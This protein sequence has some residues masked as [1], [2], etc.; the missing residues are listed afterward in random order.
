MSYQI[1]QKL[2][3][4]V[5]RLRETETTPPLRFKDG[6]L[7]SAMT[8][9]DRFVPKDNEAD[10]KV[11]RD[12]KGIGTERTRDSIIETLKQRKYIVLG[13]GGYLKPTDLGIELIMR[14]PRELSDPVTT[15]KWEMALGLIEQGK[16]TRQQFDVMIRSNATKLVD[17]LKGVK[18][19][20]DRM[21]LK[22]VDDKPREEKPRPE[23]DPSLPGHGETCGKCR[24]GVME[25]K[26]F[27][28]GKKAI[29]CSNF[30]SCKNTKWID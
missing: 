6:T 27:S 5:V 13:Q 7:I 22:A 19:D 24:K 3:G 2:T 23:L 30:R 28:S 17:A 9:I 20:L 14:L 10:R 8:N 15:A 16:M 12:T 29:S 21:G 11:L 18:F 1:A 25:G 26:I 4:G